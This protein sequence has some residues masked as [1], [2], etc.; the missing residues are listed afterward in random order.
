MPIDQEFSDALI[1]LQQTADD[2]HFDAP[3]E[4]LA[5]DEAPLLRGEAVNLGLAI[6]NCRSILFDLN[7]LQ[8]IDT[9]TDLYG[10]VIPPSSSII[11]QYEE[12]RLAFVSVLE[13]IQSDE[14][15]LVNDILTAIVQESLDE[16]RL[17]S[18]WKQ[19]RKDSYAPITDSLS[20]DSAVFVGSKT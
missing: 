7:L 6:R 13:N 5:A 12:N 16:A 14:T 11:Q 20:S 9:D 4:Q 19:G 1:E 10:N 2:F 8:D 17:P 3:N 15:L 18:E